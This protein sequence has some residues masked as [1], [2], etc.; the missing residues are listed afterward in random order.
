VGKRT[1]RYKSARVRAYG[2][3][4]KSL[5]EA[6]RYVELYK[7]QLAGQISNL[8]TSVRIP[9][10]INNVLICYY[11][12]DFVYLTRAGEKIIEDKSGRM[13]ELYM[14]KKKLLA[15]VHGVRVIES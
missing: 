10:F 7:L 13:T 12:A 2:K 9:I 11:I 3:K 14:L 8:E 5:P 1:N 15:A 4:F 6:Q